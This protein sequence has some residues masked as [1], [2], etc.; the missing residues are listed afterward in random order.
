MCQFQC[1]LRHWLQDR[2]FFCFLHVDDKWSSFICPWHSDTQLLKAGIRDDLPRLSLSSIGKIRHH[3]P[4]QDT[5]SKCTQMV[6]KTMRFK[7]HL[8]T[9]T[10]PLFVNLLDLRQI[11]GMTSCHVQNPDYKQCWQTTP[12]W[13]FV[14]SANEKVQEGLMVHPVQWQWR[15]LNSVTVAHRQMP[16]EWCICDRWI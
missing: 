2:M 13:Q 8:K 5:L 7:W 15:H 1:F 16:V 6:R 3:L 10:K 11:V 9:K 4:D 14:C 12:N